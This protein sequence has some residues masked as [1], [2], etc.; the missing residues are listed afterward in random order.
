M[1]AT[2]TTPHPPRHATPHASPLRI[3]PQIVQDG[4]RVNQP[5]S[6]NSKSRS[7]S[8]KPFPKAQSQNFEARS[9]KQAVHAT[10]PEAGADS[11]RSRV[12]IHSRLI[13]FVRFAVL[14]LRFAVLK[15]ASLK[16]RV[17]TRTPGLGIRD[18]G[19]RNTG[20]VKYLG[21]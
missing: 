11:A 7:Q 1:Y 2:H 12:P 17:C 20:L 8:T 15:F 13:L 19:I 10:P 3:P 5:R 6:R 16:F 21:V 4:L 18:L 9:T 14:G